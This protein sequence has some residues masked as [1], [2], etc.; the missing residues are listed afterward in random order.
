M[1]RACCSRILLTVFLLVW[2]TCAQP[3]RCQTQL[4][5]RINVRADLDE[6]YQVSLTMTDRPSL[7]FRAACA[8]ALSSSSMRASQYFC[9]AIANRGRVRRV[10]RHG[11]LGPYA[12]QFTVTPYKTP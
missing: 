7:G 11:F 6:L 2:T 1:R 3:A 5:A 4:D 12:S 8:S 10:L 9:R